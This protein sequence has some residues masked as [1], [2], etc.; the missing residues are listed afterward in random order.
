MQIMHADIGGQK[1][2]KY[3]DSLH[4]YGV[5]NKVE[6]VFTSRKFLA[7]ISVAL[8]FVFVN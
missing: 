3:T 8:S 5:A 6:G 2:C 4:S 7:L 1:V